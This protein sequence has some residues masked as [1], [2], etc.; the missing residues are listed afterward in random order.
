[1]RLL[2]ESFKRQLHDKEGAFRHERAELLTEI[3][4]LTVEKR[5]AVEECQFELAGEVCVLRE[6]LLEKNK[7]Y[8]KLCVRLEALELE[9]SSHNISSEEIAIV[10]KQQIVMLEEQN[11]REG[12]NWKAQL[13][14]REQSHMRKL[15]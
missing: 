6:M 13:E 3:E 9:A 12:A 10:F 4:T 2:M 14:K 7:D 8:D 11:R 5:V 1:M 15:I